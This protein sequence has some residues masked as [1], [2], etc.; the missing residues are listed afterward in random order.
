[1]TISVLYFFFNFISVSRR[2]K[3]ERKK[4]VSR[5]ILQNYQVAVLKDFKRN[6]RMATKSATPGILRRTSNC[7][8]GLQPSTPLP[9]HGANLGSP[10][11]TRCQ[12]FKTFFRCH[13][14]R[15]D[16]ILRLQL[17]RKTLKV[18]HSSRRHYHNTPHNHL[19]GMFH[20][21]N[22][23]FVN[24]NQRLI[25]KIKFDYFFNVNQK[26]VKF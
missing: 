21:V 17:A 3:I 6:R 20:P 26:I 8:P 14:R 2:Q 12:H 23:L 13:W 15:G 10:M 11:Q 9:L 4:T 19:N 25:C 24:R 22:S 7:G 16:I 5:S 18:H 1:V